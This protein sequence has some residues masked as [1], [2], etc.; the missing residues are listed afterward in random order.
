VVE[1]TEPSW[2]VA[3]DVLDRNMS[4]PAVVARVVLE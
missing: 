4:D 2:P 1:Y 3:A